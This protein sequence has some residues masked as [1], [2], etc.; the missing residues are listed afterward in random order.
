MSVGSIPILSNMI[1][2]IL[3]AL[4]TIGF[5]ISNFRQLRKT[6]STPST[7]G[8]SYTKYKIKIFA[9]AC[10]IAGCILGL[11]PIA[12]T[13]NLIDVSITIAIL[14]LIAKKRTVVGW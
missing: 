14:Y 5:I 1:I 11:L 8:I 3:F 2:D 7:G 4:G 10:M 12:L 6:M 9:S 13:T